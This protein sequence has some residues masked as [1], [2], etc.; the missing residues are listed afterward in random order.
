MVT[1]KTVM[2]PNGVLFGKGHGV[3]MSKSGDMAMYTASGLGKMTGKG[4]AVSFR[5]IIYFKTMSPQWASLNSTPVVFEY[6]ADEN[7][8]TTAKTWAWK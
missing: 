5:G 8:N 2:Q 4:S 1:Y 6:E 3:I 7:G